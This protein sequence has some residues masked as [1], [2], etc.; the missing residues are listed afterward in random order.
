MTLNKYLSQNQTTVKS[1]AAKIGLKEISLYRYM[2][3]TRVP[4]PEIMI[5][6]FDVTDGAVTPNDFHLGETQ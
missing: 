5:R 1:F 3:N 6:I 4:R 2:R